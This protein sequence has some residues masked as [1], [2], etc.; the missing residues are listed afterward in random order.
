MAGGAGA[1]SNASVAAYTVTE[2]LWGETGYDTSQR[3]AEW[4]CAKGY[5][6]PTTVVLACG[7]QAPKG[8]DA[9]AGAALAGKLSAPV[10]LVTTNADIESPN[11]TTI[12]GFFTTNK[13]SVQMAY[14]L[15]GTYVMPSD[16]Y[17]RITS[18]LGVTG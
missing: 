6:E 17:T 2:R 7:A 12:D 5:L 18:L 14:V 13:D 11:T 1:I 16:L 8:T 9:L 10:L 3:I 4:M 15:G